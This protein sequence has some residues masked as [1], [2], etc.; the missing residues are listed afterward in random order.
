MH[1]RLLFLLVPALCLLLVTTTLY[2]GRDRLTR[3]PALHLPFPHKAA[4]STSSASNAEQIVATP[5][6]SLAASTTTSATVSATAITILN[7]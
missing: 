5:T 3:I 1:R 6:S 4:P 7:G 2:L